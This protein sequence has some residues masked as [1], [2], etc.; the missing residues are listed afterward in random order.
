M[1]VFALGENA[2][3]MSEFRDVFGMR[4]V[5]LV[6][7]S[8]VYQTYRV[9]NPQAPYPQ[10][11]VIDQQG[12]VRYWSDQ[13]DPQ[14]VIRVIDRLLSSGV[15]ASGEWRMACGGLTVSPN[16]FHRQTTISLRLTPDGPRGIA[17]FDAAGRLVRTLTEARL[18]GLGS[19]SWDGTDE[20]GRH[21]PSGVYYVMSRAARAVPALLLR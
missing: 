21:L 6:D 14:A 13:F 3:Q 20:K 9:P 12:I 10:D 8:G 18:H 5:G 16:P 15:E 19:V 2:N 17:V 11:Y 7:T 1:T 4:F